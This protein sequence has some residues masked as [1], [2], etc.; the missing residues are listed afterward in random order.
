MTSC[1]KYAIIDAI[2]FLLLK[3]MKL[4]DILKFWKVVGLSNK[5]QEV[6]IKGKSNYMSGIYIAT[7]HSSNHMA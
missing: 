5:R 1:Y 4:K 6:L 3:I 7:V 2:I